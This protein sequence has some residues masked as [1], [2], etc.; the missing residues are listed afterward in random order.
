MKIIFILLLSII[1]VG[2]GTDKMYSL[3]SRKGKKIVNEKVSFFLENSFDD[4]V[5]TFQEG[6]SLNKTFSIR[7]F[8]I[9]PLFLDSIG[10]LVLNR[11]TIYSSEPSHIIV[12]ST[13]VSPFGRYNYYEQKGVH[14]DNFYV[15]RKLSAQITTDIILEGNDTITWT[16]DTI[17]EWVLISLSDLD[18]SRNSAFYTKD[19]GEFILTETI[20][21]SFLEQEEYVQIYV[22]RQH[23]SI[24]FSPEKKKVMLLAYTGSSGTFITK[25][26][27]Q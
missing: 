26:A 12:D 18:N 17:N 9:K 7:E 10:Y 23:Q 21:H 8:A 2:C 27:A 19:D 1:I 3:E 16:P 24:I 22:S 4:K 11:D 14:L 13:K 5:I 15:P 25:K 6:S 20:L